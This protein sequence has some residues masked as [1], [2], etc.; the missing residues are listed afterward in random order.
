MARQ[1]VWAERPFCFQQGFAAHLRGSH[2]RLRRA[3]IP[4]AGEKPQRRPG[5]GFDFLGYKEYEPGD[6]LRF[7]DVHKL[8]SSPRWLV[9]QFEATAHDP[10][11]VV[12]DHASSTYYG[13][14]GYSLHK[15]QLAVNL[16]CS[17]SLLAALDGVGSHFGLIG[18]GKDHQDRQQTRWLPTA[19]NREVDFFRALYAFIDWHI[20]ALEEQDLI[21]RRAYAQALWRELPPALPRNHLIVV[22]DFWYPWEG[23]GELAATLQQLAHR[24]RNVYL[25]QVLAPEE[26]EPSDWPEES[27]T[28]HDAEDPEDRKTGWTVSARIESYREAAQT[29][30]RRIQ[31]LSRAHGIH[32]QRLEAPTDPEAQQRLVLKTLASLRLGY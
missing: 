2:L 27:R 12:L 22:S 18:G 30:C 24:F 25:F 6:D 28:V 14:V 11:L 1:K 29:H 15:A 7:L 10:L 20:L 17:V 32:Y 31:D 5:P 26:W 13:S 8:A 19:I 3:G 9:R 16:A 23:E 21:G 4:L